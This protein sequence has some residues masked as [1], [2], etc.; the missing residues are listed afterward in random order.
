MLN[1]KENA[2]LEKEALLREIKESIVSSVARYIEVS[3]AEKPFEP[4]VSHIPV[5]GKVCG[6]Q[7]A[8]N[9]VEA[10]LD[11]WY[12]AGRF[13]AHF[14]RA[15]AEFIGVRKVLTTNS[16]SSANL[17]ASAALT[18]EELGNRAIKPGDEFITVAASFPT[19]ITPLILYGAVPVFIDV[20]LHTGNIQEEL[21]EAAITDKTKAIVLAHSLGNPFNASYLKQIAEKHN[22]WLI[23]DCC[24][25]LGAR[26]HGK[27]VGTFG[28]IG[29]LSFYPAHHITT[30][31][32]GAVFSNNPRLLKI[33]ESFRDWGRDCWCPS[34][35]DNTCCKRFGWTLGQLPAGYDHKYIYSRMGFNLK[36]TDMQAALGLAQLSR[37]EDFISARREN[38]DFLA[39]ELSEYTSDIITVRGIP[40]AEPSWFGFM[41]TIRQ[42]SGISR[43]RLIERLNQRNIGTR[44]LFAGDVR[45]QPFFA[46]VNHRTIGDLSNTEQI[47]HNTFW[48]GVTPAL[49][50]EMRSYL[51]DSLKEALKLEAGASHA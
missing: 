23:E 43:A 29:T 7:E 6:V 39:S 36:I 48:V 10:A 2:D 19:T 16:G 41:I 35:K 14:E 12:T 47:L 28:D 46:G 38:H 34:G 50:T 24:D 37:L 1:E 33:M 21:V 22:L 51:A 25:A 4:G 5:S 18:A 8:V 20:D 13:N 26:L 31:E 32:G 9:I 40:G 27:H 49:T 15:L 44:L 42:E 11:G 17:I 30:G 3:S 45:K